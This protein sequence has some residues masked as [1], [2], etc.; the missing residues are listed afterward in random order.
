MITTERE[1]APTRRT[2]DNR[3]TPR[4]FACYFD[5]FVIGQPQATK[6]VAVAISDHNRR[7][8]DIKKSNVL[9]VGP[10]GCGKTELS[11]LAAKITDV[12]FAEA[13]M[14]AK[15]RSGYAGDP[16]DSV[17]AD[18]IA[19]DKERSKNGIVFLDEIDK[20]TDRN[21]GN[22][23]YGIELQHQL[24]GWVESAVVKF[25]TLAKDID[26]PD[27]HVYQDLDTTR[28]LFIAAG[29]FVGLEK[30]IASRLNGRNSGRIASAR[31]PELYEQIVPED[32]INFGFK[33]ELVARFPVI[34]YV[35]PLS[36][37]DLVVIMKTSENSSVAA[38]LRLLEDGY[39]VQ[40][41]LTE[42]AYHV[43]AKA[44]LRLDSGA[45][46]L[47]RV[48]FKLFEDIKFGIDPSTRRK[49]IVINEIDARRRLGVL[50]PSN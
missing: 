5:R 35:R 17:F 46:S 32:L 15:V 22:F 24:I 21:T 28:V 39:G 42:E 20:I 12:P 10:S 27:D 13:K 8:P 1:S 26:H 29:A 11:R 38:Q 18:L 36:E 7:V 9:I 48:C 33:P 31:L 14:S 47:E 50:C 44:A 25:R 23:E 2:R 43:L 16:L 34:T 40:A 30:I 49:K 19:L 45:R 37:G 4:E 6:A 3:Q 41:E